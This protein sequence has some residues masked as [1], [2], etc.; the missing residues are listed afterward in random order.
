MNGLWVCRQ[1]CELEITTAMNLKLEYRAS[2]KMSS[3]CM[4]VMTSVDVFN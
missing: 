1:D 4:S 3:L 2:G